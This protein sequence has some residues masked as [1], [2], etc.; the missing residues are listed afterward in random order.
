[1]PN[2][3]ELKIEDTKI[4]LA[5]LSGI[6]NYCKKICELSF[7]LTEKNLDQFQKDVIERSQLDSLKEGFKR[8]TNLKLFIFAQKDDINFEYW[9]VTLEVLV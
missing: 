4:S 8:V 3:Q 1:M 9:L 7:T 6:F 5:D 2:L